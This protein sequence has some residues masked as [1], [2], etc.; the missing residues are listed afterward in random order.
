MLFYPKTR[1]TLKYFVNDC[2]SGLNNSYPLKLVTDAWSASGS[3][4]QKKQEKQPTFQK[5][6]LFIVRNGFRKP[7]PTNVELFATTVNPSSY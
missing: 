4:Q 5:W 3:Q 6:R 1:V 7:A 2:R